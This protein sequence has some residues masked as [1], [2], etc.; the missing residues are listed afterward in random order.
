MAEKD[1]SGGGE[2]CELPVQGRRG[3]LDERVA[4]IFWAA[5]LSLFASVTGAVAASALHVDP[6]QIE[7]GLVGAF[8]GSSPV[9]LLPVLSRWAF[10]RDSVFIDRARL[11][12]R[13]LTV[14]WGCLIVCSRLFLHWWPGHNAHTSAGIAIAGLV[15]AILASWFWPH[16]PAAARLWA[17]QQLPSAPAR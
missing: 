4:L 6:T 16:L 12:F 2:E 3:T 1:D 9:I 13:L 10:G 8:L 14:F 15:A 5:L 11:P 17:R 7:A